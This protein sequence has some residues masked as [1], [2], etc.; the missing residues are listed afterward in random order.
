MRVLFFGTYD[1]RRH[2]RVRVLQEGFSSLGEEVVQC[3]VPLGFETSARVRMLQRPWLVPV[4]GARVL[5]T[6][7]R[8]WQMSKRIAPVDAV[9]VGYMGHFDVHLARRL[10]K[11][12][13]IALDHLVSARDT[14]VDRRISS[15]LLLWLLQRLDRSALRAADVALVDT[16]E[17]LGLVPETE[18]ARALVVPV[19]APSEWFHPPGPRAEGPLKVVFFGL[20]TPLQGAPIIGDAIRLLAGEGI[21]FTMVGRGQESASTRAKAAANPNVTWLDWVE[22]EG[23]PHLVADHDVCLGIF[24]VGAKAMRVVPNKVFQGAAAG[25]AI[26]TSDTQPQRRAFADSALFV[27]PG[28]PTALSDALLRLAHDPDELMAF[29]Q[30]A[31]QHADQTFRPA[32]VVASLRERL[33]HRVVA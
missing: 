14:A 18:R 9:I 2:P 13:P 22:P 27:A 24:G 30:A 1:A 25:C 26:V 32:A 4:F 29:R 28:D 16:E 31:H 21:R 3:N 20:Y 10:W 33:V 23:L 5:A 15:R 19:G 12:V 11:G 6:W 17:H 8:L 7:R